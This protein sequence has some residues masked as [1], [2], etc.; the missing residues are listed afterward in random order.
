MG[1]LCVH[2]IQLSTLYTHQLVTVRGLQNQIAMCYGGALGGVWEGHMTGVD[3]KYDAA[4][5]AAYPVSYSPYLFFF[6]LARSQIN[7]RK[8]T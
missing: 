4:T 8:E 2:I 7:D 3:Q 5:M 1:V 6:F